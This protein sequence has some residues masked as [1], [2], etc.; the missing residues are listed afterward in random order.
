MCKIS[1]IVSAFNIEQY[2][3]KCINSIIN[4]TFKS[5]E[6]IIVN[7]GSKDNTLTIVERLSDKDKRIKVIDKENGGPIE[8][9]KAGL[10]IASGEYILFIDGD[11]WLDATT[12]ERLY[13]KA[14][15]EELDIVLYDGFK[16]YEDKFEVLLSFP[17]GFRLEDDYIKLVLTDK[18]LPS[19]CFKFIRK[20]FLVDNDIQFPSNINYA[21][22][23]AATVVLFMYSPKVGYINES[24]Y[25]Y[26]QRNNS[27]TKSI[28]NK[29]LDIPKA[30]DFIKSKLLEVKLYDKYKEEFNYLAYCHLYY[31]KIFD[32]NIPDEI[33]DKIYKSY[34]AL[35]IDICKNRYYIENKKEM[36]I[37][38]R[39]KSFVFNYSYIL[40]KFLLKLIKYAKVKC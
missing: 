34:R 11:D 19:M 32:S 5:I 35:K 6:I 37:N 7:D 4:Q 25:Y 9:R 24:L 16:V 8:A 13:S 22:D 15:R 28:D 23:L 36:T 33:R 12:L 20:K 31:Y 39:I 17:E 27:I 29:I 2:I 1:V 10:K 18:I 3:E 38:T 21:E 30:L 40:G 26:Y 14:R